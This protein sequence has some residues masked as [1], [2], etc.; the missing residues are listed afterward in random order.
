MQSEFLSRFT[1]SAEKQARL[2]ALEGFLERE[3]HQ[4]VGYPCNALFDYSPLLRF[5]AY[6]IN[7]IGDPFVASNYHLNTHDF[8]REVIATF[9]ELTGAPEGHTWGYV[10]NGGTEG[11]HYGLLLGRELHPDGIVYFSQDSHYSIDKI[12]RC[13]RAR[14]IMIR[15]HSDG[16]LDLNDLRR[17][18]AA[19]RDSTPIVCANIG[20]TM[21]GAIDDVQGIRGVFDDLAVRRFYIHADAALSGMILPFLPEAPPWCFSDGIDSIAISGH[22]MIGSPVPCGVVLAKREN[23][24][25]IVQSVEYVGTLD[26]TLSGSRN[27]LTPLFL[28]YA[29]NLLGKSGFETMVRSCIERAEKAHRRLNAMG[30]H[31]F[32]HSYA[33]TVVFD[34]PSSA[35]ASRWQLAC[36]GTKAHLLVMPHVTEELLETFFDELASDGLSP[37]ASKIAHGGLDHLRAPG[38]VRTRAW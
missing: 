10:T 22:K 6:P 24:E 20:T 15:S 27:A 25:R 1:L 26:T 3:A 5:L 7:N 17:T 38:T 36:Q 30:R 19:H 31:S 33:N 32:R 12:L 29:W 4:F 11:N 21:K 16:R 2:G 14:S 28:W 18:V 37:T 8:E 23:V 9:A 35:F 13:L 34:R